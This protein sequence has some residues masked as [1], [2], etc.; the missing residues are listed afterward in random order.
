MRSSSSST[1]SMK[2]SAQNIANMLKLLDPVFVELQKVV[3]QKN[4]IIIDIAA[5][6]LL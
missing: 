5:L 4:A 6:K 1:V 2:F 3:P